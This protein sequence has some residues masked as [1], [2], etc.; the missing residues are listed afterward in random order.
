MTTIRQQ[1]PWEIQRTV[2]FSLFVRELWARFG[3]LRLGYL[4]AI[5][6]PLAMVAA[7]SGIKILF[8]SKPIEGVPYPLFFTAGIVGYLLFQHISLLALSAVESNMGLFNY[9]HIKPADAVL[10]RA[11]VE[12]GIYLGTS[13][14]IYPALVALGF[15][16]AWNDTLLFLGALG[17]LVVF[18]LGIG[19][20][21]CVLGPLWQ[22]SKK[23]VPVLIRPLFFLSGVFFSAASLPEGLKQWALYNPLLHALELMRRGMFREYE[24]MEGSLLYLWVCALLSLYLGLAVYRVFRIRIVTSGFIK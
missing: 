18:S 12:T 3:R 4:W 17:G 8:G 7:F 22:E 19:F 21:F 11:M 6:E 14:V 10:S 23:V 20:M 13:L 5:L 24:S 15:H 1:T 16:F 2:L 9:R